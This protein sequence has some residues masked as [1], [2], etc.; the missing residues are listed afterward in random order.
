M[1]PIKLVKTAYS[2][3]FEVQLDEDNFGLS[4]EDHFKICNSEL[5]IHIKN[6]EIEGIQFHSDVSNI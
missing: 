4:R 3:Y 2:C 5:L 1:P 6:F